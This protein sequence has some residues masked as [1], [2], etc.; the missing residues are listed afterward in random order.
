MERDN[1]L[2]ANC[3]SIRWAKTTR[4]LTNVEQRTGPKRTC[5]LEWSSMFWVSKNGRIMWSSVVQPSVFKLQLVQMPVSNA[6][7][8]QINVLLVSTSQWK[9]PIELQ[10]H[11]ALVAMRSQIS[12]VLFA[13]W[14]LSTFYWMIVDFRNCCLYIRAL[15]PLVNHDFRRVRGNL[16]YYHALLS[17]SF[18]RI[19]R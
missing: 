1:I 18:A 6:G 8:T 4:A 10:Y 3:A 9:V 13:L 12:A 14:L 17:H 11:S 15:L 5:W 19:G 16:C 2:V 7:D